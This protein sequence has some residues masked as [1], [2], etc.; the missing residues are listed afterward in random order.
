MK[1]PFCVGGGGAHVK[2]LDLQFSYSS[3]KQPATEKL[4]NAEHEHNPCKHAVERTSTHT[5]T[6]FRRNILP[7]SSGSKRYPY[8]GG[9]LIFNRLHDAISQETEPFI[10]TAVRTWNPRQT[11]FR[12]QFLF[13][14]LG[15]GGSTKV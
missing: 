5:D 11:S 8:K 13:L 14:I 6:M 7:L 4:L 1:S 15:G 9:R 3:G 12:K 10:T 2:G